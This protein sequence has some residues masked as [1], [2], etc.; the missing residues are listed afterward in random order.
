[1][2]DTRAVAAAVLLVALAGCGGIGGDA[3]HGGL[4]GDASPSI[5]TVSAPASVTQGEEATVAATVRQSV[6]A[7]GTA[8]LSVAIR[9]D[10]RTVASENRSVP[11]GNETTVTA[12]LDTATL[13]PGEYEIAVSAGDVHSCPTRHAG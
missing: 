3:A 1:M 9:L 12:A 11:P 7:D 8:P 6:N 4:L 2:P 5:E 10:G 13:D